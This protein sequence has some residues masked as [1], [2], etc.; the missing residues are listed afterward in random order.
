MLHVF[1]VLGGIDKET[2]ESTEDAIENE[3]YKETGKLG[4]TRHRTKTNK[5]K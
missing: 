1:F 5:Q 3:Q 4:Y 2:L